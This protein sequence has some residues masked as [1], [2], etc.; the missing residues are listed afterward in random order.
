MIV[1]T[2]LLNSKQT[3]VAEDAFL[4]VGALISALETEFLQYAESFVPH[5]NNALQN[6]EDYRLCLVAVGVIGDLSRALDAQVA[7]YCPTFMQLL[8]ADL[9][10]SV[11]HRSV[12]PAIL[13][14][15]GDIA[16]AIGDQ[17]LPYL[18]V[19][20]M[21]L[22]Q[23]GSMQADENNIDMIDYVN[24]LYEGVIEAYIGIV[25]GLRGSQNG[26]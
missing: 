26:K 20:T 25:Q 15:F 14:I 16:L 17:F 7:Q 12:K 13:S 11:L 22:K 2:Q 24:S 9:Q 1:T 21:V 8:V 19:V 10:S 4:V 3:S 6:L 18:E 23:A 5:L